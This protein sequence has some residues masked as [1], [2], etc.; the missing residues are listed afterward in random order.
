MPPSSSAIEKVSI[1]GGHSGQFCHHASDRLE[2]IIRTYIKEGFSWVGITEHMAPLSDAFRYPDE[3]EEDLSAAYL[4]DRFRTYF[5]ECRSL[6]QKYS[7]KIEIYSAF[8]TETY[9]G[10]GDFVNQLVKELKP[11]YLVGSV[12]HVHDICIDY[13]EAHF[14]KAVKQAGSI[15]S[16][17]QDYFDAQFEML[18]ELEPSVVGHF[19]LVRKYDPDYLETLGKPGVWERIERNLDFISETG[20]IMDFNLR[21]FDKTTEQ[22]P[23]MPVL[24]A[25]LELDIDVVPGDDSHGVSS[26]GRNFDKGIEVLRSLGANLDW[27]RPA[28][29][30]YK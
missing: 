16:L 30:N 22:Y 23:S 7:S 11:D 5:K 27:A 3:A 21:G 26:V 25:A 9:A 24:E 2:D 29:L 17:Y 12:H 1:H 13:D 6:R 20:L 4:L 19:D 15:E 10:S 18:Q 28:L 8:E 14:K